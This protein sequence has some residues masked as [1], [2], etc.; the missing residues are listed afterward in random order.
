MGQAMPRREITRI[1]RIHWMLSE[2][3]KWRLSESGEAKG[4][5]HQTPIRRLLGGG[6]PSASIAEDEAEQID[7]AVCRLMERCPDQATVL[8]L[9]YLESLTVE[10]VQRRTKQSYQTTARLLL[11]AQTAIDWILYPAQK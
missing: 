2:W 5:P 3:A 7:R 4:Y 8:C 10:K 6:L 11:Q 9:Y 1:E